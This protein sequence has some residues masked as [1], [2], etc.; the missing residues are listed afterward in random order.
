[1]SRERRRRRL[2]NYL[3]GV[4]RAVRREQA[5]GGMRPG[6]V[7]VI[8]VHH[9][10]RCGLATGGRCDC[11]PVVGVPRRVDPGRG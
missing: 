9:H 10:E 1:M 11:A 7:H 3:R 6:A 5:A 4:L 8:E 2:A